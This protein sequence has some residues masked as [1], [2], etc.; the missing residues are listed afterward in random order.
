MDAVA[1]VEAGADMLGF[2]FYSGSPRCISPVTCRQ[3]I[4][5]LEE[6]HLAAIMTGIFVNSTA[7]HVREIMAYC[8]LHLAQLSGDESPEVLAHL[9]G[10]GYKALRV[11]DAFQLEQA[12]HTFPPR[13]GPPAY[14]IDAFQG[15]RYGGT[16]R[17][18]DWSLAAQLSKQASI[19]LAGGLSP[20][21]VAH[22]VAQVQP[23]GVDVASGVESAPGVKDTQKIRQFI[24]YARANYQP[25]L[26]SLP[27]SKQFP[28]Q[29]LI[30]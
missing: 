4:A 22:A 9:N 11:N 10:A 7:V 26:Q 12:L 16:G 28:P 17:I 20:G 30:I 2:N 21:N 5:A 27:V 3:I 19:L 13:F 8:G 18:A 24:Q 15:G 25:G 6:N 14:L 1:A 23:W 29:E